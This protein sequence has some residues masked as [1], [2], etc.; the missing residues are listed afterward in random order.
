MLIKYLKTVTITGIF[1]GQKNAL[2]T[3]P[4]TVVRIILM[5]LSFA[6][7]G[8][9]LSSPTSLPMI[10]IISLLLKTIAASESKPEAA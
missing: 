10:L 8:F 1:E 2:N 9:G 6:E 5:S 3:L 7:W 4:P